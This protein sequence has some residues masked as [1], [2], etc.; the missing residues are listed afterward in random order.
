MTSFTH[1]GPFSAESRKH[2]AFNFLEKYSAIVDSCNLTGTPSSAFYSPV[3]IFRDTK[4]DVHIGGDVIWNGMSRLFSPFSKIHHEVVELRVLPGVNGR[5][6]VYAE[7]LTHFWF[8]GE[9]YELK[10]PRF[11]VFTIG[12]AEEGTGTDGLQFEEVRLFWDT[13]V[14]GRFVTE[15]KRRQGQDAVRQQVAD[16]CGVMKV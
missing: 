7:F 1:S 5:D 4:G 9:E 10:V 13:G 15:K 3:A 12:K 11:F 14:I 8:R 2:A 16:D 6:V